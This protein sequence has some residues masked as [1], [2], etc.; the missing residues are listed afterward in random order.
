MVELEPDLAACGTSRTVV[1]L[2]LEQVPGVRAVTGLE[3]ISR[4]TLDEW[5]MPVESRVPVA[6]E[7]QP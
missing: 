6:A 5:L 2:C 7:E 4:A 1:F 3:A